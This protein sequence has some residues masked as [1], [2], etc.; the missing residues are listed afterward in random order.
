MA[1]TSSQMKPNI[2]TRASKRVPLRFSAVVAAMSTRGDDGGRERGGVH[3]EQLREK[4]SGACGHAGHGAAQGQAYTHPAIQAHRLPTS[5]RAHGYSP[6]GNREL[7]HDFA[8]DQ[9]HHELT[10][11]HQ[12]VGPPHQR[13]AGDECAGEYGVH[14]HH[15]RQIGEPQRKVL[16]L[17]HGSVEVRHIAQRLQL[18][19][20]S[21]DRI[22]RILSHRDLPGSSLIVRQ[23]C[24]CCRKNRNRR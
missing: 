13:P 1:P 21:I 9:A 6:P 11:A 3:A 17:R 20:V 15:R 24:R 8:E 7:R 22:G 16:P 19:C 4:G 12:D 2:A 14:A 18:F 5:R 23:T 10:Q